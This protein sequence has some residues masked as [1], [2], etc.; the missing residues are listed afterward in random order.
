M[1]PL[2]G[3]GKRGRLARA[4]GHS[5]ISSS[6]HTVLATSVPV[7]RSTMLF[8]V[9]RS[10][11]VLLL[12]MPLACRGEPDAALRVGRVAFTAEEV[13][14]LPPEQLR[15]LA[16]LAALGLVVARDE[17]GAV[18][19]PLAERAAERARVNHLPWFLAAQE[20]ELDEAQTQ[21]AYEMNPEWELTVR[22]IVRLVPRWAGAEERQQAQQV[23]EEA[24]RRALAGEDF[25]SLAGEFSEEPGAAERGGLLQPGREGAWVDPFWRAALA[26]E[27]GQI[28]PVVETEYG[29]HV[30]RLDDRQ[31]VPFAD[32]NR[33]SVLRRVIPESQAS[34]AMQRWLA[35]QEETLQPDRTAML[36]ARGLLQVGE[37]PD[38]LVLAH[39][40]AGR[41]GGDTG[42]YTARDLALFR[43]ALEG[44]ELERLDRATDEGFMGRV[45]QDAQEAMW[46]DVAR[47]LGS[48]APERAAEELRL[49]W[50]ARAT[51]W[52]EALGFRRGMNDEEIR[53]AALRALAGRGQ[54]ARIIR[55]ELLGLRPLLWERYDVSGTALPSPTASSN[56]LTRK[57]ETT[58]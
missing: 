28:S 4:V 14:R 23:V 18:V 39:W 55:M 8:S 37:A 25:S 36:T 22:H 46:A 16:D 21:R 10:V 9:R 29:Y 52:G 6:V 2:V 27:P 17:M 26:L 43:A 1:R 20:M 5:R 48:P 54:E 41:Q 34:A 49:T 42:R 19:E 47:D 50:Q 15:S 24:R 38:T 31:P 51:R 32:A 30:L 40:P 12:M 13:G 57:S 33:A 53:A 45:I 35:T 11:L 58:G 44:E 56:S 3:A 7:F